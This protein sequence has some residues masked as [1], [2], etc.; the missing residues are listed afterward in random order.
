RR[1]LAHYAATLATADLHLFAKHPLPVPRFAA[2]ADWD[3]V[4]RT[5]Y[6][7]ALHAGADFGDPLAGHAFLDHA[8]AKDR[9]DH[10]SRYLR[11]LMQIRHDLALAYDD[12]R[13]LLGL[14]RWLLRSGASE[15]RIDLALLRLL[16][17]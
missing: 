8:A 14:T 13:N 11:A 5:L 17:I 6:R 9:G 2:G 7:T 10:L 15:M 12:G 4:C 3:V 16:D 1:L